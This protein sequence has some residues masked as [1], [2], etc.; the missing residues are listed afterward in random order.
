[1]ALTSQTNAQP[2][3]IQ[4]LDDAVVH[5]I[6][7]GEVVQRPAS[8]LKEMLEN[9]LD[10]GARHV[11]V[12]LKEGGV[13]Y[14]QIQDDGC[15]VRLEDMPILCHRHTTSKL[16]AYEDLDT[17]STLGF[18]GEALA[19]ISFVSHVTVTTMTA[20]MQHG[21][22]VRYSD[23]EMLPPGPKPAAAVPGT[24]IIVEDMFYN[25]LPRKRAFR[26][27]PEEHNLCLDVLQKYAIYKAGTTGFTLKRQGEA[28]SDLHTLP[29]ASRLDV[30]R[31]LFG[32]DLA[33][34]LLPL[35]LTGGSGDVSAAVPLDGPLGFKAEGFV[36]NLTHIGR[37][38]TLILFI[39]GRPVDQ[40]QLKRALEA[41]YV[42]QNPKANKPWVFLDLQ[43][44][45][46]HVEVNVHPTKKEVGFLHQQEVIDAVC[47]A[48]EG[49]LRASMNSRSFAV[50]KPSLLAAPP[51]PAAVGSAEEAAAGDDEPQEHD[52]DAA[53]RPASARAG[54]AAA[55][56]A[57][58]QLRPSSSG[59]RQGAADTT[60]QTQQQTQPY[61]QP[62]KLVRTDHRSQ[63]IDGF[64]VSQAS[65]AAVASASAAP[66]RRSSAAAGRSSS[67]GVAAGEEGDGAVLLSNAS[68]HLQAACAEEEAA[69]AEWQQQQGQWQL[70]NKAENF[71]A[72]V[73]V[74]HLVAR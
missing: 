30:I 42:A 43:L 26:P 38:S 22:R 40:G 45:P 16:R 24:S 57:A 72:P 64:L 36:S 27:G 35:Q 9:S 58:S 19:S 65:A 59:K 37:R 70:V 49:V 69:A 17:I 28:R 6:A 71:P 41:V 73:R 46:R 67:G 2:E 21:Y 3:A 53:A 66:R 7:A 18:R 23:G 12:V 51:A 34:S 56:A 20:S 13:K 62:Q 32:P 33:A 54:S 5:R 47:G 8:A 48:V 14:M 60:Q 68:L 31:G 50:N 61:Y 29:T 1:M 55:G 25:M 15:G 44:P 39:N 74:G 52:A 63:T 4:R 10:A 11:T